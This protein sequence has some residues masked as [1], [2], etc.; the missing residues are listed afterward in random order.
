MHMVDPFAQDTSTICSFWDA[1]LATAFFRCWHLILF[2]AGWSTAVSV[3]SHNVHSLSIQPTL[4]TALGTVLG[5]VV[6]CRTTS[7]FER[8]N[9]GRKYW[10]QIV[11]STRTLSRTIWFS[12]PDTVEGNFTADEARTRA[13]IEKKTAINLLEAFAVAVKHYLR[14]EE[15]IHY[16][17]LYPLVKYLPGYGLP[18]GMPSMDKVNDED[19]ISSLQE[20][21]A[22]DEA[23]MTENASHLKTGLKIIISPPPST[24]A[25]PSTIRPSGTRSGNLSVAASP[26]SPKS[27]R[28]ARVPPSVSTFASENILL[29]ARMPPRYALLDFFPFSL[30]LKPLDHQGKELRG[31]KAARLRAKR[32]GREHSQNIPLEISLYLGSYIATL[33]QRKVMET[34]T[35][36]LLLNCLTQLVDALTGLERIL[37]TPIP[38][39]YSAH[40]WS[41]TW[42][43]CFFLPFQLYAMLGWL[44][45]PGTTLVSFIFFGFLAM[46]DEIENPFSYE[47]NDLNL[48]HFT[49]TIIHNEIVAITSTPMPQVSNWAFSPSNDALARPCGVDP[50][51][52]VT[53]EEWLRRGSACMLAALAS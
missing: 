48:D 27:F 40:L 50:V 2:F 21:T 28:S 8:Y 18:P 13:L 34:P 6:S 39:S 7:S 42:I 30:L 43:Y 15:G 22:F 12:V 26:L 3:I 9:E 38:F 33:Q 37:T 20:K 47:R 51:Q 35:C 5:F 16:V 23:T 10:A 32:V 1:I 44:T 11:L 41:V 4:L 24:L 53:P 46:G 31:K 25:V 19:V 52:R 17:D 45:I 14:G 29:P 36:N 49:Q